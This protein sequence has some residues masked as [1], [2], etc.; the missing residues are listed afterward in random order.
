VNELEWKLKALEKQSLKVLEIAKATRNRL[1][2]S[3]QRGKIIPEMTKIGYPFSTAS[4][5]ASLD[6]LQAH[7]YLNE[8][9]QLELE[10]KS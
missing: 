10:E 6:W 9:G 7:G 8:K 1:N 3:D 5:D 2:N 4:L